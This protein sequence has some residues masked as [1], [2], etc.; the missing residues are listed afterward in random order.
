MKPL[1]MSYDEYTKKFDQLVEKY[2]P[3]KKDWTP[4]DQAIYGPKDPYRVPIKE[5]KELQFKAI[6]YQFKNQYENNRMY[7]DFCKEMKTTPSD[8]KKYEDL[9][10][11]PL[12]P[13]EFYKD[14][15]T[16]R[17][18]AL[19]LANTFTGEIPQIR[20][21]G[22]NPTFD[23]VINAFN[24]AGLAVAYSSGTS[25]RHTFIPR[26]MRTFYASE[27]ALGKSAI[28]MAYPNWNYDSQGYLLMPNPF[29][30]NVYAGKVCTIY[31][32]AIKNVTSAIDREINTELIKMSMIDDSS[33]KA[34]MIRSYLARMN[35]KI[36]KDIIKW[37]EKND[38]EKNRI[39]FAGAPFFLYAV[40][41]KLKEQ[42]RKFDFSDRSLILTGGGWKIHEDKRMPIEAFRKQMEEVLG[43]RP[44]HCLDAYGMV[45]GNGWMVHCPEGHYLHIPITYY[46]PLVLDDEFKPVSYNEYGRFAFLDGAAFSYPGF[47]ISGDRVRMLEHCPVCDRPGP[48]LE[49]EVTRASGKEMRGCAEELRRMISADIG[50]E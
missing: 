28:S 24:S 45:E 12:V 33:F 25:G 42:G 11:I 23:D 27:Y 26:D 20:I 39:V 32:D 1:T 34:K 30:T 49:P 50:G 38:K 10:K 46:H 40:T 35:K 8:I 31:Y 18:F 22:K 2:I 29:K 9:K 47:I 4:A 19:W 13:G 44:E 5:A 48:V 41:N 16:G 17:D 15:P 36:I 7:H 3:P 37:L 21:S 6:K 43:I 14:Y